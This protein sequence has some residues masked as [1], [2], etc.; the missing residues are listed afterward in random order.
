MTDE[1][2]HQ[3]AKRYW[4][5]YH[6]PQHH[7]PMSEEQL[8]KSEERPVDIQQ[9]SDALLDEFVALETERLAAE[10]RIKQIKTR[11]K[12]IEKVLLD[13]WADRGQSQAKING[14]TVFIRNDFYCSK[15]GGVSTGDVCVAMEDLGYSHMVSD[16]YA[17]A[18]LKSLV[19]EMV[20]EGREVPK[21]LAELLRYDTTPRLVTRAS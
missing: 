13:D 21:E 11:T 2:D 14:R 20:D 1:L 10:E 9:P 4:P 17:P 16:S 19:R 8:P 15:K 5:K 3:Q 18:S 12:E 7:D 6:D